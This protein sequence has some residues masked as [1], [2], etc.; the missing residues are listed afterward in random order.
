ML[1]LN[2]PAYKAFGLFC[3]SMLS[4]G[5]PCCHTSMLIMTLITTESFPT[6]SDDIGKERRGETTS[7]TISHFRKDHTPTGTLRRRPRRAWAKPAG[8][9]N[10]TSRGDSPRPGHSESGSTANTPT[11]G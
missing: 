5:D 3:C 11:G 2:A 1:S 6:D 4:Q 8:Q 9:T 10:Q 7:N